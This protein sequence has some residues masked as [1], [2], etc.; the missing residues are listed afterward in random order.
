[1]AAGFGAVFGT[2]I[3]GAVFALEV[4]AIGR[5]SY[6]ALVPC[7]LASLSG[8]WVTAAWGIHHA[9]YPTIALNALGV[10]HLDPLLLLKVAAAAVV[11]GAVSA[12]FAGTTH[13]IA[14]QFKR[15]VPQPWLRPAIGAVIVIALT[16][17]LGTRDYLGLGLSSPDTHS[18]TI[19]SSFHDGGARTWNWLLK[20]LF[21]AVSLG[22]GFKGGEVTPLFFI[23]AALGN[24]LGVLM[25]AP[26]LL[27]AALGF[28]AVFAG[29]S[30]TPLA[31]TI[32]GLELFGADAAVYIATACFIAYLFSGHSG[33]YRAQRVATPKGDLEHAGVTGDDARR[34][35]S[36]LPTR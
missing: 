4:L 36:P 23:G 29:A 9:P 20:L 30:N 16:L 24:A 5:I 34:R 19:L 2:P 22:S 32:M 27:F 14:R 10:G 13:E 25:H 31:C 15:L 17:A 11:F 7:L 6:A 8:D 1:V 12:I 26:V 35:T 33:I 21:T 28:V 3:T 18:V